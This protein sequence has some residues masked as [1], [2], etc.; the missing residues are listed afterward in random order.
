MQ[1]VA[2]SVP[3]VQAAVGPEEGMVI[4]PRSVESVGRP[5]PSLT[6]LLMGYFSNVNSR[7]GSLGPRY[8]NPLRTHL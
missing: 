4:P 8:V 3:V 1:Q 7:G 5:V 6:L 2:V